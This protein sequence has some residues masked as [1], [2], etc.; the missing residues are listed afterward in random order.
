MVSVVSGLAVSVNVLIFREIVNEIT[1]TEFEASLI[2]PK[3]GFI[4]LVALGQFLFPFIQAALLG[5]TARRLVARIR[6]L[7]FKVSS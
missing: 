4:A 5:F 6:L 2:Y 1:G 3:C 7:Y